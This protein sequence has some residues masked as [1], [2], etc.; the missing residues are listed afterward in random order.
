M[1][2]DDKT[3]NLIY[4]KKN[5]YC[6]YDNMKL[7]FTNYGKSCEIGAWEVDHSLPVS[8]GGTDNMNNLVPACFF[9]NREKADMTASEFRAYI[10]KEWSTIDIYRQDMRKKY[11][12]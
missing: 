2:Y 7:T 8:R 10:N 3:L 4:N 12:S 11:C 5:G 9:C 1:S 6:V